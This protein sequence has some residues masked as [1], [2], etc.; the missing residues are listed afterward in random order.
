MQ[1]G[2]DDPALDLIEISVL[3]LVGLRDVGIVDR[4]ES[5]ELS[6]PL[7]SSTGRPGAAR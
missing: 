5:A 4:K 1:I 6:T 7:I 2:L 3:N